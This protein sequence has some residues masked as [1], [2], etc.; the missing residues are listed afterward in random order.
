M[1]RPS[2]ILVLRARPTSAKKEGSG[3]LHIQAVSRRTVQSDQI[4]PLEGADDHDYI[5][6]PLVSTYINN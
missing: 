5:L 1:V 4:N 6:S 2:S 3:E